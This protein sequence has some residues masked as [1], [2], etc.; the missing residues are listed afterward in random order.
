MV[1]RIT[2]TGRNT[3]LNILDEEEGKITFRITL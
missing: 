1:A 3:K 2:G